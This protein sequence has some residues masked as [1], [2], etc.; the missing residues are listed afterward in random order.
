[1]A[2]KKYRLIKVLAW[3][4]AGLVSLILLITLVFYLGRNFFMEKAVS[5]LNEQ[6][7][8]EVEMGK[9]KLIPFVNFPNI[10]LQLESVNYYEQEILSDS[11]DRDPIISLGKIH[12]TLDVVDL[13]RG[14]VMVSEAKLEEGKVRLE[15]YEDSVSNL[16]YALGIRFG[17]QAG[18]DTTEE[19]STISVDLDAFELS[20]IILE[21]DNRVRDDHF[22]LRVNQLESRFSYLPGLIEAEVKLDIDINKVKYLTIN[23]Q[24]ERN[25]RLN[26]SIVMNPLAKEVEVKPSSLRASGLD[27]E[28]WGTYNYEDIPFLDFTYKATNEGL[29]VLN[30]LFRGVLDLD[31][32]EQIGSGTMRLNGEVK[33]NLGKELPVIRLNG[34]ANEIGFRIKAL[35]K[36]VTGISFNV[37]AT[38]GSK[39]DLSESYMDITG[40][41]ARF[42]EGRIT[43]NVIVNNI[44]SPELNIEVDG[45]LNLEGMERMLKFDFLSDLEGIVH[46]NGRVNGRVDRKNETFLNDAGSLTAS[47]DHVGFVVK[48]D[49]LTSDSIRELHG[50][51]VLRENIIGARKMALEYNSNQ[52]EVGVMTENLLL[53]LLDFDKDV[54]AE[55]S[56]KS[57]L[58]TLSTLI[59]DTTVARLLGDELHGLQFGASALIS[60][61]DLDEFLE[62]DSIPRVLLSLDS[63]EIEFPMMA[64]IS[65]MSASLTFGPDTIFLHRLEGTIG[66]SA[67]NFS[68]LLANYGLLSHQDSAGWLTLEFALESDLM[69]AEDIFTFKNEFLLPEIYSTE[70]LEDFRLQGRLELPTE[71]LA[72]D[73]VPVNFG[74]SIEN[75]EWNF[76]YYPLSFDQFIINV[77]RNGDSLIID[78][79]EGNVGESNLKMTASIGN[80]T[81]SL[82]ENMYGS[83][84]L[85]SDLLDFNALLYYQLPEELI[86]SVGLDSSEIREPPRLD[87]ISYPSFDFTVDIDELRFGDFNIYGMKGKLRSTREKIFFLDSLHISSK[88]GGSVEF[89]GHFN[90]SN[91]LMYSMGADL[92]VKD[93]NIDDIGLKLQTGEK[94]YALNENFKGVISA[95]G[96]AEIFV[97]PELKVDVPTTTAMFNVTVN[98]G[99]LI[100]F[101][102]LQAAGKFLDNK[103]LDSVNFATLSNSFTLMDSKVIIPRMKVESSVGLLLIEGDQGLD[104]S[105]LYLVR[106]P[107][108]L[109]KQAAKSVMSAEEGKEENNEI[110]R[111]QRGD[112][113]RITVWSNGTESD[114]K[115][116]DKRDKFR[117]CERFVLRWAICHTGY[118]GTFCRPRYWKRKREKSFLLPGSMF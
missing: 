113:V 42:P 54:K 52:L 79:F 25:V 81:D 104:K 77:R 65:D 48:R 43:A 38:N 19:A 117:E 34:E 88:G 18:K 67:F 9:M 47:L 109:A 71:G 118:G 62:A 16:E 17:D 66:E 114:Y 14:N 37:F 82:V 4:V 36:D 70:Y 105:F 63:F 58:L 99:A 32:I 31:E 57:E 10:T 115:L 69:R 56:V 116:G 59:R 98:D 41:R 24:G 13:I 80:F 8:G 95:E 68:G 26:G 2:R 112:F 46:L 5:Y 6:Q 102:P 106:V 22:S 97:T 51:I 44:K 27:F 110:M 40:F 73:S 96:L 7:P 89:N 94:T 85:E 15:I 84:V 35:N 3:I 33:G 30:F 64:D 55:L 103:N 91:P 21:M 87:Q 29:E 11:T 74:L 23:E 92:K 50:E 49:S 93:M 100:H 28:T 45:N 83:L 111:M 39:L 101:T 75:L 61:E 108:K 53:Y 86:D 107:T 72:L 20:G 60:R 1:M 90:A 76:R 78:D 12:V